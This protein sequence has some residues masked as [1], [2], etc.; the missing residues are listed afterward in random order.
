MA[1]AFMPLALT[2][3]TGASAQETQPLVRT[4]PEATA[5]AVRGETVATR[6]RPELDPLGVR[7]GSFLV[8]PKVGTDMTWNDNVFAS[9]SGTK[10]D[11][12]FDIMPELAVQ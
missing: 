4:G 12:V 8:Y 7:L 2:V 5:A 3:S 1:C 9:R 10:D 11:V 6:A